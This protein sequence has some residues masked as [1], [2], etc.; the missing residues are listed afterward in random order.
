MG[1]KLIIIEN[2]MNNVLFKQNKLYM[3]LIIELSEFLT[4]MQCESVYAYCI[5]DSITYMDY[6][7]IATIK[8]TIHSKGVIKNLPSFFKEKNM[9]THA[10]NCPV[11]LKTE[12]QGGWILLHIQEIIIHLMSDEMRHFYEL[13]EL[14]YNQKKIYPI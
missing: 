14:W 5:D 7:I 2:L 12:A 6:S 13:E 8:S 1:S 10:N 11:R 9:H 3:P 4:E